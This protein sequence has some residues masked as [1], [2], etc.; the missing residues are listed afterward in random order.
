MNNA[1]QVRVDKELHRSLKVATCQD[2]ELIAHRVNILIAEYLE[3]RSSPF[4]NIEPKMKVVEGRLV[5]E[6]PIPESFLEKEV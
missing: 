2:G 5:I 1:T 6:L 3:K 4:K